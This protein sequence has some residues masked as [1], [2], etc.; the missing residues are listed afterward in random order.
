VENLTVSPDTVAKIIVNERTGTIVI[1][2]NVVIS[3]VA[4]SYS[5]IDVYIG[6]MSLYATGNAASADDYSSGTQQYQASTKA[7]VKRS[8]AQLTVVPASATLS[9]LV[10]ALKAIGASPKDLIA[11]LQAMKKSG[12]IKAP[13]EVI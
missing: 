4:V 11:I 3:P 5:G 1:G 9:S 6:D 10:Q 7:R 13:L 8:E 12:A 2:E